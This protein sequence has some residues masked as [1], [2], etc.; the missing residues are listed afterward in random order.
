[1]ALRLQVVEEPGGTRLWVLYEEGAY[2]CPL[3]LMPDADMRRLFDDYQALA[4]LS[5]LRTSDPE[6]LN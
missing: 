6:L 2:H 5:A 4:V 3:A 1:M